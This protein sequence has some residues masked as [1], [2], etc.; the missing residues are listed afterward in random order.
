M[1]WGNLYDVGKAYSAMLVPVP[2]RPGVDTP[3]SV[4]DLFTPYWVHSSFNDDGWENLGRYKKH[5]ELDNGRGRFSVHFSDQLQNFPYNCSIHTIAK[6]YYGHWKGAVLV[7]RTHA[8]GQPLDSDVEEFF[9]SGE[10]LTK[11]DCYF[12]LTENRSANFL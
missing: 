1:L 10:V 7:L 9:F 3:S 12:F 2:F 8:D 4:D 11:Y 5:I 6:D